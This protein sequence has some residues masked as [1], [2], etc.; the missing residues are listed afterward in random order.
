MFSSLAAG[1]PYASGARFKNATVSSATPD[2][3]Q[4]P[5]KKDS[6]VTIMAQEATG[7]CGECPLCGDVRPLFALFSCQQHELC[8]KCLLGLTWSW[9]SPT[10][11]GSG[12][13]EGQI[14]AYPPPVCPLCRSGLAHVSDETLSRVSEALAETDLSDMLSAEEWSIS[15]GDLIEAVPLIDRSHN[16]SMLHAT[17]RLGAL[18]AAQWSSG[19]LD[20]ELDDDVIV[21][22]DADFGIAVRSIHRNPIEERVWGGGR[23]I[24][25]ARV[26]LARVTLNRARSGYYGVIAPTWYEGTQI[27][28]YAH[29]DLRWHPSAHCWYF[30]HDM[31]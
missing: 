18:R 5:E 25:T 11:A 13:L 15:F 24:R 3:I 14:G 30:N 16:V 10:N 8:A 6:T 12:P 9:F 22:P 19:I 17:T 29:C 7:P 20:R 27:Y 1:F 21:G 28:N 4:N 23:W 2:G 26:N 31:A